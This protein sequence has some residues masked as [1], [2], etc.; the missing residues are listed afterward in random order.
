MGGAMP[1]KP[2]DYLALA[3]IDGYERVEIPYYWEYVKRIDTVWTREN[4]KR[5][6]AKQAAASKTKKAK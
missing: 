2:N 4:G 5:H 3:F 1:L 6:T